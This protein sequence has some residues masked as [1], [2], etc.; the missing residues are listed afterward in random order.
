[1]FRVI[2]VDLKTI[3]NAGYPVFSWDCSLCYFKLPGNYEKQHQIDL[4]RDHL[5]FEHQVRSHQLKDGSML[6]EYHLTR[7]GGGLSKAYLDDVPLPDMTYVGINK[8]N[9]FPVH[10]RP[11]DNGWVEV[12]TRDVEVV[13]VYLDKYNVADPPPGC[14]CWERNKRAKKEG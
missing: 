9:D 14:S 5:T 11:I 8:H 10:L 1:M 12:C 7:H 13:D 6:V 3:V 4:A 2:T